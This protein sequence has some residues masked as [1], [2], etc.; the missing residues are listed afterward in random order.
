MIALMTIVF[1]GMEWYRWAFK[2]P[3]H[4]W[5]MSIFS[6]VVCV[7]VAVKIRKEMRKVKKIKQGLQGE[8]EV[9]H[10]LEQLR[11]MG[12]RV[13]HD[14]PGPDF[15]LDHVVIHSSGIYV[16]ETKTLSKPTRG[17]TKLFY[18]G[19][20]ISIFGKELERDP[21]IQVKAASNWLYEL[22]KNST[23]KSFRT[24]PVVLFPGWYVEMSRE[25]KGSDLWVLNPKALTA[26]IANQNTK[27]NTEEVNMA[28]FHLERYIRSEK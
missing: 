13:F 15:N 14:I 1:A 27:L 6:I 3:P 22:L 26:F 7:I 12:A 23:G 8:K 21:I 19:Q 20:S 11:E 2:L 5:A 17:E 4:P 16:I 9:G 10:N 18:N 25:A 28:S 24:R